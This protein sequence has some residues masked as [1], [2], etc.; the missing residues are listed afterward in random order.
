MST[1]AQQ[2]E[3]VAEIEAEQKLVEANRQL[4]SRMEQ[5]IAAVLARV[6]GEPAATA[7]PKDEAAQ[8]PRRV[9]AEAD[10]S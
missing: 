5:K 10:R 1:A 2:D 6:W 9:S 3:F 4:L 8:S 7:E